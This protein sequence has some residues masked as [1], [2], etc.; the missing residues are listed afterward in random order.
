MSNGPRRLTLE[1]GEVAEVPE[2][3][4]I[5]LHGERPTTLDIHCEHPELITIGVVN[6][7]RRQLARM[8]RQR[9]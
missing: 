6:H 2:S 1:P 9:K 3:C 4:R 5:T 7:G 8:R